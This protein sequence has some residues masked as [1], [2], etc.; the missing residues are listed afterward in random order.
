MA[1]AALLFCILAIAASAEIPKAKSIE[2]DGDFENLTLESGAFAKV[3]VP[4]TLAAGA[5]PGLVV[6][7]HG[8]GNTPDDNLN[9]G[10]AVADHR[11]DVWCAVRGSE[12]MASGYG[13]DFAKDP[14]FV[15][16][17]TRFA[18]A[19]YKVDPKRVVAHGFSAGGL[20]AMGAATGH[21]DLFAGWLVTAS[22]GYPGAP[23]ADPKGLR[24]VVIIGDQDPV[25]KVADEIRAA[26]KKAGPGFS[27]WSVK[28]IG[29]VL[30][31]AVYLN[32]ALNY[33]LD[34]K[35]PDGEKTLPQK[36]DHGLSAAAAPAGSG[37]THA[38]VPFKSRSRLQ[39]KALAEEWLAKLRKAEATPEEFV[40]AAGEG[41]TAGAAGLEDLAKLGKR[42]KDKAATLKPGVWELA[43]VDGGFVLLRR[44]LEGK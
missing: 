30:P 1:R 41:A 29:H 19:H 14:A 4:K 28:G 39:A 43:E 8:L 38:F 6:T 15:A 2:K 7:M 26:V 21:K 31:D 42:A 20:M 33:I 18:M 40:A 27:F 10:R 11:R 17:L 22:R 5:K 34:P 3:Y 9:W 24:A 13:W 16:D 35:S 44:D 37:F 36:A 32:D 25:Y 12:T 23:G